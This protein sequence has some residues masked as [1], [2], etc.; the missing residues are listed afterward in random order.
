MTNLELNNFR[1]VF[2]R[3]ALPDKPYKNECG[4]INLGEIESGGTHWTCYLKNGKCVFITTLME[5]HRH[6]WNWKSI[7]EWIKYYYIY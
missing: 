4:I 7:L 2:M 6:L 1:G 3:Q 5:K